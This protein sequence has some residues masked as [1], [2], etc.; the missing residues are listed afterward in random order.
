ML[1]CHSTVQTSGYAFEANN[2]QHVFYVGSGDV[3]L[4]ELRWTAAIGRRPI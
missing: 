2:T 4:H 1:L 3:P